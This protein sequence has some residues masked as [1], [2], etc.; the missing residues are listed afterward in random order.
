MNKEPN[1]IA[2]EPQLFVQDL[3]TACSFYVD[4]LGFTLMFMRG[5]PPFYAQVRRGGACLNL[6]HTDGQVFVDGFRDREAD[7]LSATVTVQG[8]EALARSFDAAGIEWH[9]RLKREAWGGADVHSS[10]PLRQFHRFRR[11]ADPSS[12]FPIN[13]RLAKRSFR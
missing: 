11:V 9:Q 4:C 3:H 1:L 10:R 7:A 2:A 8:I 12:S 6:R 5:D 13:H